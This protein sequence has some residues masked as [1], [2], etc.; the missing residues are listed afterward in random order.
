MR[1]IILF[2]FDRD[3][4]VCRS[5]VALLRRLNPDVQIHG[6]YGGESGYRHTAF[7]LGAKQ[8]LRLDSVYSSHRSGRW[9]WKNGDLAAAAWY[10]EFGHRVAFD[11][12]YVIEW[13]LLLLGSVR[14]VFR[15]VPAGAVGLTSL[16]PISLI[17]HDWVWT[18]ESENR[19]EWE[20]LL[21]YAQ[22]SWGYDHIP[23]ACLGPGSCFPRS[24]L[25]RFAAI[26]P[27]ELSNDEVRVPLF[28]QILG[29]EMAD[30]GLRRGW[31][32]AGEDRFFNANGVE[33]EP[34]TIRAELAKTDGRRAFHPVRTFVGRVGGG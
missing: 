25:A 10:R 12:V 11:V 24:F 1:P 16:T 21:Q 8:V 26:D 33:V 34:A 30:T 9:N 14:S 4:L 13:D 6:L 3:P 2:R 31:R 18:Q 28:A 27:P 17:E 7:R 22:E 29:Y 19:R 32:G 15:S 5:R 23:Y 20:Q